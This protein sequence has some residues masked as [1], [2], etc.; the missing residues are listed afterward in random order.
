MSDNDNKTGKPL[1][2]RGG[3][4]GDRSHVRQSFSHGRSKSVVVEKKRKRV[5]VPKPGAAS[6]TGGA[7]QSK[8]SAAGAGSKRPAGITDA[9]MD[10]RL[11]A[12][13]AAKEREVEDAA[14]RAVEERKREEEREER[15]A[16]KEAKEREEQ[17]RE[18][19]LRAGR[20]GEVRAHAGEGLD[21]AAVD[22]EGGE[23]V[24]GFRF[25]RLARPMIFPF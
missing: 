7:A 1:G 16:E 12:L 9:E 8:P 5:V 17:E 11:A 25:V 15:R 10:R 13:K 21:R 23:L 4:G 2:V 19:R 3:G 18:E 20:D 14:K 22:V 24:C 6:A